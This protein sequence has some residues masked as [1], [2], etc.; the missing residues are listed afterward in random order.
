MHE[1]VGAAPR[2]VRGRGPGAVVT[3]SGSIARRTTAWGVVA[4]LAVACGP[5]IAPPPAGPVSPARFVLPES[6]PFT[7]SVER[8]TRTRDGRPGHRYWQQW[9]EYDLQARLEPSDR[10]V[11]GGASIR[12]HNRSPDTLS[13]VAV[14]LYQNLHAPA[15][16]GLPRTRTAASTGG[17]RLDTVRAQG[18]VLPPLNLAAASGAGYEVSGTIAW[19]RL[20][21]PLAPGGVADLGFAWEFTVPPPTTPRMGTDG[22]VFLIGL[23][24]PQLA[25]YDD[26]NGWHIDQYLGNAEFYMGYADYRVAVDVPAGWLVAATGELRNAADVLGDST[27]ARLARSRTAPGVVPVVTAGD[28]GAG[29]A[30]THG[31]NG[32]LTW[33]WQADSVRDFIW[34]ASEGYLWD[35]TVAVIGDASGDGRADTAAIHALYR[36]AARNWTETARYTRHA[37]ESISGALWPYPYPQMTAV[38]GFVFGMEYPM[39]TLVTDPG[40]ATFLYRIIAHEVAHMWFP[41]L[42]GSDEKRFAWKDEGKAQWLEGLAAVDFT[43]GRID[44]A[45]ESMRAYAAFARTGN[46]VPLMRHGDHYPTEESYVIAT[47]DKAAVV[48]RALREVIGAERFD[49]G[50]RAYGRAWANRHPHAYDFF[51]AMNAAAGADLSWFWRGWFFE[52]WRLDQAIAAVQTEGDSLVITIENRAEMPMPVLL[53]VTRVDGRVEQLRLPVDPWLA[54]ERQQIVRT[55]GSPAVT[56]VEIDPGQMLPDINRANQVWTPR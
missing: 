23:W 31:Q 10:R 47:Y 9:S 34:T 44:P 16:S 32:R 20:P 51:H 50:L 6:R 55:A 53:A 41:M 49:S 37:T 52:T 46:E 45:L 30:T 18:R 7:S 13:S 24:Y 54:G 12:Y 3:C 26:V 27:R 25:V 56:R 15:L 42:V 28:R 1:P 40:D 8:G 39:L 36:P 4:L 17:V 35:A 11:V 14:H 38:E 2:L 43:D 29:R 48:I 5:G 33:R 22:E 19:L 21:E